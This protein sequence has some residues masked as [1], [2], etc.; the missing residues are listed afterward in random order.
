[1]TRNSSR[2]NRRLNL[3]LFVIILGGLSSCNNFSPSN[4]EAKNESLLDTIVFTEYSHHVNTY[5]NFQSPVAIN[6]IAQ[7]ENEYFRQYQDSISQYYGTVWREQVESPSMN[8]NLYAQ[9]KDELGSKGDSMHCTVYAVEALKA[10][11][12][13]EFEELETSHRRIWRS[14]EHAGWSLGY[15][16][17]NEWKWQAYLVIDEESEEYGHCKRAYNRNKSYPVWRQ[18]DIPLK[19]MLIRGKDDAE[20]LELLQ[21]NEF[22]WGFSHQGIHTWI[23]R[24][25]ELKEC[26]WLG[27]PGKKYEM[28]ASPLF[29]KTPFLEYDDYASHV[30]I[31]PPKKN[32]NEE[33]KR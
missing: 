21:A 2:R 9:Y 8:E 22:G 4:Q 31:F 32:G 11:F 18:P 26:N 25:E 1:M 20:I 3:L 27:A 17:V 33:K 30:I 6:R 24:F 12:G 23:T 15:L 7:I 28:W 10:G 13:D 5:S 29:L 14:R 16:L 19:K